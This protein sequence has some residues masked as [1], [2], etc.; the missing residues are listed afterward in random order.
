MADN[1]EPILFC[2]AYAKPIGGK[3]PIPFGVDFD[4]NVECADF[5]IVIGNLQANLSALLPLIRIASCILK[6][7]EVVKTLPDMIGPPPDP[8]AFI[9]KLLELA[10][11]IVFFT[12]ISGIP[13]VEYCKLIYGLLT[14]TMQIVQ[15]IVSLLQINIYSGATAEALKGDADVQL[16]E[17]GACLEVQNNALKLQL[18]AKLDGVQMLF[19]LINAIIGA[20]PP[21]LAA[22]GDAYPLDAQELSDLTTVE[23]LVAFVA[24]LWNVRKIFGAC[25]LIPEEEWAGDVPTSYTVITN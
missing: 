7:I 24:K 22:V 17:M 14:F 3:I 8:T 12:G 16:Q 9:Q 20:I 1:Q 4:Y 10:D 23:P 13:P 2:G 25:G 21:L 18:T 11:C 6:L 19:V 15:C 5:P